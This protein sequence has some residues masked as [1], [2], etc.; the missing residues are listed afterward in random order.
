MSTKGFPHETAITFEILSVT[1]ENWENSV[2]IVKT[3][4]LKAPE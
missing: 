2:G 4:P 1:A 3:R